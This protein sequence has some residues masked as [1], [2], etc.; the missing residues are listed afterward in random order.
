MQKSLALLVFLGI[1]SLK[2]VWALEEHN[3]TF[4]CGTE[5]P[6][7]EESE[8]L[9]RE[10]EYSYQEQQQKRVFGATINVYFHIIR[11]GTGT[12]GDVSNTVLTNQITVLNQAFAQWGYTFVFVYVDRTNN[13]TWFTNC[14]GTSELQMKQALRVGGARDLNI[15]I[16]NP[17]G[18]I[19][20]TATFP[21]QYA[22]NPKK[23]GVI[24][25]YSSLPGG[26]A[27][28]YN[29]GKT[30]VHEVGHWMGLYHT[31]QGSC[32]RNGD[33]VT[34]T[35]SEKSPAFG[36]PVGR[37]TCLQ[38]TGVDP[39]RNFMDYTDDSCMNHFTAG[40]D[41]RMDAQFT[42]YRNGG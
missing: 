33:Y 29:L 42:A 28:P 8:R 23:D 12:S 2:C 22:S 26:S 35:A 9:E 19:L 25:L 21:S 32:T 36:C 6:S 14:A 24:L 15:Y 40:Q 27:V 31:F 3:R 41:Y 18:G 20:G 37:D 13:W 39:I 5:H 17:S 7:I 1:I 38:D 11:S 10:F 30:A 16:C 34:D 4:S